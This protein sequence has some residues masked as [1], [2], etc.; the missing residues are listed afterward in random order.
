MRTSALAVLLL[1]SLVASG[2]IMTTNLP[3]NT[4]RKLKDA[5]FVAAVST[6]APKGA[7]VGVEVKASAEKRLLD[8]GNTNL[9]AAGGESHVLAAQPAAS[10]HPDAFAVSADSRGD[11]IT[12]LVSEFQT[13]FTVIPAKPSRQDSQTARL[14]FASWA[15]RLLNPALQAQDN[16]QS[17]EVLD[18][19]DYFLVRKVFYDE[20]GVRRFVPWTRSESLRMAL[21]R[22]GRWL[23]LSVADLPEKVSSMPAGGRS[24]GSGSWFSSTNSPKDVRKKK[25]VE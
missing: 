25:A 3:A 19:G 6:T 23:V 16:N 10:D 22:N 11:K 20:H 24:R 1:S 7:V 2:E 9:F 21:D 18:E 12:A 14:Q 13:D 4:V 8:I 17:V 5:G 15:T